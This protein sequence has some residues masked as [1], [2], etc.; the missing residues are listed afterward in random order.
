MKRLFLTL[1]P[2]LV[3][4]G[5]QT[6]CTNLDIIEGRLTKL[7]ETNRSMESTVESLKTE[8]ITLQQNFAD[9]RSA[10]TQ[11]K[12]AETESLDEFIELVERGE[13]Q[14]ERVRDDSYPY[15]KQVK[16]CSNYVDCSDAYYGLWLVLIR[17]SDDLAGDPLKEITLELYAMAPTPSNPALDSAKNAYLDHIAAWRSYYTT[18]F[19]S[20]PYGWDTEYSEI[21]DDT[22]RLLIQALNDNE[23]INESFDRLCRGMGNAQISGKTKFKTRIMKICE[24]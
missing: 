8:N 9:I 12:D 3:L 15:R 21:D 1:L 13:I 7:E 11:V 22:W 19:D 14:L 16:L 20:L 10:E 24:D 18:P 17:A 5:L 6:S 4:A 2:I 23:A